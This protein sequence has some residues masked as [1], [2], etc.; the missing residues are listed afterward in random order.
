MAGT[1]T[2][3][4]SPFK[5][6]DFTV[7]WIAS[8]LST[9]GSR[10]HEVGAGWLMTSLSSDPLIVALVQTVTAL[11]IF[12]FALTAGAVADVVSRRKL[13]IFV[14]SLMAVIAILFAVLI[15]LDIMTPVLL[16]IFVF[17][18]GIG[19]AFAAPAKQATVPQ[20]IPKS[21]LQSAI[22]LN[23]VGFNLSRA[24]GP[25]V[26]G[27]LILA[28][29]IVV[30]FIFNAISFAIIAAAY[31]WWCPDRVVDPLPKEKIPGAVKA[32]LRYVRYSEPLRATLG[33]SFAFCISASAFW[34]LLPLFVKVE[35]GGDASLFGLLIGAI[36][37]GAVLGVFL[38]PRFKQ[39]FSP[40][41]VIV[42]ASVLTS[43][44]LMVS[45][46]FSSQLLAIG[47]AVLF[48]S[49]W[50]WILS[51][52]NVSAQLALPDWVR[53]RGL[54][55]YLMVFF[56]SMSLGSMIWGGLASYI[57]ISP[58]LLVAAGTLLLGTYLSRKLP[59]NQGQAVE[60]A[61]SMHWANPTVVVNSEEERDFVNER[62][63]VLITIEYNIDKKNEEKFLYLMCYL[64]RIRKQYGA[65]NWDV[66]EEAER[67]GTFIEYFNSV[68]WLDYLRH[69]QRLTGKDWEL[70]EEINGMHIGSSLPKIRRFFGSLIYRCN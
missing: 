38:L 30:P 47:T 21:D 64:G 45:G 17:I 33:R 5:S 14:E 66:L 70:Q 32:G 48:G 9:T 65:Y 56:G 58:T 39:T 67:P 43:I 18:L 55:I 63:P 4:W 69:R 49:C 6:K 3:P 28:I 26:A 62:S 37:S 60:L 50:I 20:L 23:S 24:I 16:L 13:L 8:L 2:N 54:A 61:P 12:L 59:L 42:L 35:L 1:K 15:Y 53:A 34:A 25:A 31:F 51:T 68:S 10:M 41:K 57:G 19:A 44:V 11:P 46:I 27:M 36:G 7:L 29:G 40:A 52:L 22:A